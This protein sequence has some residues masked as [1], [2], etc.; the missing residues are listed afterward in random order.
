MTTRKYTDTPTRSAEIL[1]LALPHMSRQVAAV[2]PISYAVWYEHCSGRNAALSQEI[3]DLTAADRLLDEEATVK[4]YAEHVA[5]SDEKAVMKA[6]EDF[7]RVLADMSISA[8]AAGA[9]TDR[10]GDSLSRLT[11]S[12]EQGTLPD[13]GAM[14]E[15]LTHTRDMRGAVSQLKDRLDTNQLE[16]QRLRAEV[17]RARAEA[18]I[19]VL[20]GLPNR[21]AFDQQLALAMATPSAGACLLV[22]DI[23]HFKKVND[24]FGHLFGDSVLRVVARALGDCVAKPYV[25][26]RVG[27]EEFAVLMQG[28][29]L[30]GAQKLAE[31]IRTTIA[32]SR[33]RR[34]DSQE[35]IGQ[36]T[37]SL[38]VAALRDG[39]SAEG[40][41]ER[42]DQALYASKLAG[43]NRVTLAPV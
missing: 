9:Q 1:R 19:D 2:H 10:F 17:E 22:T 38:G 3:A 6:S 42:A 23:D 29:A 21:R 24:T 43:R 5:E 40:W 34:K 33:I 31:K 14:Q 11:S 20:T 15:V 25:A 28:A 36:I 35:S 27:G 4:L 32:G 16:I 13:A 37:V 30:S 8:Q 12:I 7:H 18:L 41:L 39:D 26:A